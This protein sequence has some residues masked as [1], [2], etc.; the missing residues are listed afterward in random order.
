MDLGGKGGDGLND[1]EERG[2]ELGRDGGLDPVVEAIG[3]AGEQARPRALDGTPDVVD[4]QGAGPDQAVAGADDRQ[5][6]LRFR[7]SMANGREELG[8]EPRQAGQMLSIGFVCLAGVAVDQTQLAG[9]G[10]QDLMPELLEQAAG[11]TRVGC[12]PPWLPGRAGGWRTCVGRQIRW[13]GCGF[14]R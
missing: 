4:E 12:R 6:G 13:W 14:L 8:I 5:V 10:N 11:P 7:A 1:G 9:V 3:G 2:L